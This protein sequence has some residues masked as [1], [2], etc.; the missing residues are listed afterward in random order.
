[1][2]IKMRHGVERRELNGMHV[3]VYRNLN[4]GCWSLRA[5][6]GE[7]KGR[8][9]AHADEVQLHGCALRV[10]QKGRQRVLMEKRKNVHAFIS[11]F[12]YTFE[13]SKHFDLEPI[14]YNPYK[15]DRFETMEG[16]PVSQCAWVTFG[17]DGKTN[18][19]IERSK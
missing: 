16:E 15:M 8:V 13:V 12:F 3:D 17:M 14:R 4:S 19:M 10:N 7:H 9:I 1:M 6:D 5:K 18:A 11:G 2:A